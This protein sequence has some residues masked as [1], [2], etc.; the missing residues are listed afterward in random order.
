MTSLSTSA[1]AP[2]SRVNPNASRRGTCDRVIWRKSLA[3]A[4]DAGQLIFI[5]GYSMAVSPFDRLR[6]GRSG[7]VEECGYGITK[8]LSLKTEMLH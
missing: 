2:G 5:Y 4:T 8:L 1:P 6:A 3:V 7:I